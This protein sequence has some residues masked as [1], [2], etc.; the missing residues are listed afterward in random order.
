[1][2]T[3]GGYR[4]QCQKER[5]APTQADESLRMCDVIDEVFRIRAVGVANDE[6]LKPSAIFCRRVLPFSDCF[7][8]S[9]SHMEAERKKSCICSVFIYL[10]L[11]VVRYVYPL[12]V[13][14]RYHNVQHI[15]HSLHSTLQTFHARLWQLIPIGKKRN[16]EW[17]KILDTS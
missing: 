10:A 11:Q 13:L 8:P 1:M 15:I 2:A 9:A 17:H 4:I 7:R 5:F 6:L 12:Y 16:N 14:M 3:P